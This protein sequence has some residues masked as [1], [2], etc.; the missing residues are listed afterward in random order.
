VGSAVEKVRRGRKAL[1]TKGLPAIDYVVAEKLAD[2]DGLEYRA[3]VDLGNAYPDSFAARIIPRLFDP[4]VQVQR[5]VISLLGDLKRSDARDPFLSMLARPEQRRH[6]TR[7]IQALGNLGD[8]AAAPAI[9]PFLADSLERRRIVACVALGALKD[10]TSVAGIA[11]L[12]DDP[13]LTVRSAA[14]AAAVS[15]GAAAVDPLI[16]RF[17]VQRAHRAILTQTLGRTAATLRGKADAPSRTAF[18]AAR[19]ALLA[20]LDRSAAEEDAPA[21]AAAVAALLNLKDPEVQ[22]RVRERMRTETDPLVKRSYDRARPAVR[23]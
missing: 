11:V 3:M 22:G 4:N 17:A 12:L 2:D 7:I 19:T 15:F 13:M 16:A 23:E 1:I 20:E 21:R 8:P 9:R 6:W 14:L 10:T 5:N 18:A